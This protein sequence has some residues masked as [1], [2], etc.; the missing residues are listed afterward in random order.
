M[1][2]VFAR[3]VGW[4][5][6]VGVV[7]SLCCAT[8]S[9]DT[10]LAGGPIPCDLTLKFGGRSEGPTGQF[11]L[12]LVIV[13]HDVAACRV[14]GYPDAE[15]IGPVYP[16]FGSI[17]VLPRQTG[18]TETVT[19]R[20]GESAHAVLT[21]LPPSDPRDR[22]VPGYVRIVVSTMRGPSF[23]MALPWRFGPVLRQDAATHPGTYV[24]P[25][26]RGAR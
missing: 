15:L 4:G 5:V 18:R 11:H 12:K 16:T 7:A 17:Y 26:R 3:I 24:G 13:N 21:W 1:S 14:L 23:A 25:I 19:L 8:A 9:L 10:A 20:V 6:V 2:S 22:W